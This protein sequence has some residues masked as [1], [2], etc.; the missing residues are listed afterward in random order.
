M[1]IE[2]PN[3]MEQ[4]VYYPVTPR[5][6]DRDGCIPIWLGRGMHGVQT[7]G[8]QSQEKQ[9]EYSNGLELMVG[10]SA[11][12]AVAKDKQNVH[13]YLR[14]DNTLSL[15]YVTGWRTHGLPY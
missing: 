8:L 10:I 2:L 12:Q 1:V 14:M 4:K 15:S 11:M 5:S 6:G 7:G 13:I 9:W 3:H